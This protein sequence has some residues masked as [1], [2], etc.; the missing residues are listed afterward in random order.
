MQTQKT[1]RETDPNHTPALRLVG[2][3]NDTATM[4]QA[5]QR[6]D[7]YATR[8]MLNATGTEVENARKVAQNVDRYFETDGPATCLVYFD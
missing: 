4:P 1:T 7:R 8:L 3:A 2:A 5:Q 6:L